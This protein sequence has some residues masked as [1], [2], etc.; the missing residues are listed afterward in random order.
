MCRTAW[1]SQEYQSDPSFK[2]TL[3]IL[4]NLV[5]H[6]ENEDE[7]YDAIL[8]DEP[9]YPVHMPG[10]SVTILQRLLDEE[11]KRRLGCGPEGSQDVM[12]HPYFQNVS[13]E[14]IYH[15]RVE[16]PFLPT[17]DSSTDLSNFD[18]ELTSVTPRLTP[19]ESGK[20]PLCMSPAGFMLNVSLLVLSTAMQDE[21]R[22]F[23]HMGVY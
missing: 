11:P 17:M 19:V 9:L 10:E 23:S 8:S 4:T 18:Q 3:L 22:D 20:S 13:W 5:V 12:N 7:I 14:D 2:G 15:K 16:P 6:G 1:S 21:F